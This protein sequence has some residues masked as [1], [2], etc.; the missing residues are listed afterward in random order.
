LMRGLN[1]I[2]VSLSPWEGPTTPSNFPMDNNGSSP[3]Q[4]A[5]G[6]NSTRTLGGGRGSQSIPSSRSSDQVPTQML[7]AG[8]SW[9]RVSIRSF[10]FFF[11][12]R[13]FPDHL[14]GLVV[15]ALGYRFG[16]PGSI[17]GTT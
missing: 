10:N 12:F 8:R 7:Q 11:F 6:G 15:R 9:D 13:F 17:P 16:G 5:D 3:L 4:P 14:C 2:P 1:S